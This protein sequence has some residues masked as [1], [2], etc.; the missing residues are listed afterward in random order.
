MVKIWQDEKTE[1]LPRGESLSKKIPSDPGELY[2]ALVSMCDE[3]GVLKIK[4]F[5]YPYQF[6]LVLPESKKTEIKDFDIRLH[7]QLL[8][9]ITTIKNQITPDTPKIDL[10]HCLSEPVISPGIEYKIG[11]YVRFLNQ[12]RYFLC[13]AL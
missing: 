12:F 1:F 6:P 11:D 3:R 4:Q 9:N 8:L 5:L 2:E 13:I 10:N 7:V